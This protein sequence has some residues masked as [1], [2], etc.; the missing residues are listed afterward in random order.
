MVGHTVS[1]TTPTMTAQ[2]RVGERLR[3]QGIF[4]GYTVRAEP[5]TSIRQ[6]DTNEYEFTGPGTTTVIWSVGNTRRVATFQVT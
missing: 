1:L 5:P 3:V 2:A 4:L 6:V